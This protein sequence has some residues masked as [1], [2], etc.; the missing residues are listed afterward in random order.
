MLLTIK[1]E[2]KYMPFT[3]TKN[4]KVHI[5]WDPDVIMAWY[6]VMILWVIYS[7]YFGPCLI[8]LKDYV[9]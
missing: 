5:H 4:S 7:F 2:I 9:I 3:F 6:Y 1:F 8:L